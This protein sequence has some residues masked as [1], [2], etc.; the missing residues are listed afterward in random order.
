MAVSIEE[1]SISITDS[2]IVVCEFE[3]RNNHI[4]VGD[5][6]VETSLSLR[7]VTQVINKLRELTGKLL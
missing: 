2:G 4:Y 5:Q 3:L 6:C 1:N 7:E